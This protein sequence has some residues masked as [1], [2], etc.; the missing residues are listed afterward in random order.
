MDI[1]TSN[2]NKSYMCVTFH[3]V[4]M[5][6]KFRKGLSISLRLKGDIHVRGC[7]IQWVLIFWNSMLG[8]IFPLTLD[9][10]STNEVDVK[11][12]IVELKKYSMWWTIF[13]VRCVYHILNLF[14]KMVCVWLLLW[15]KRLELLSLLLRDHHCSGRSLWNTLL[16]V[17]WTPKPYLLVDV[18]TQ[19]NSTFFK[20][21][22]MLSTTRPLLRGSLQL[23]VVGSIAPSPNAWDKTAMLVPFLKKSLTDYDIFWYYISK[24]QHVFRGFC[25]INIFLSDR[26]HSS[27]N[28]ICEMTNDMSVMFDKY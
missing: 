15:L 25:E 11:D 23:I 24:C 21:W 19:W 17:G 28:I 14:L 16:N 8:K 1:W 20:C 3:W 26:C 2:Q 22:G 27:D 7:L 18:S 12:V 4:M 5:N 6:G 13:H 9:N 10:S